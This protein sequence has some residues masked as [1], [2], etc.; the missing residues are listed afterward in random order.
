ML[1]AQ[2]IEPLTEAAVGCT[3]LENMLRDWEEEDNMVLDKEIAT[4]LRDEI[5]SCA[6]NVYQLAT[7]TQSIQMSYK[8]AKQFA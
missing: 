6:E 7:T 5:V 8:V 2:T 1:E 3:N 4:Q